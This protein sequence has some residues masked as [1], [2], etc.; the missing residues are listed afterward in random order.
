LGSLDVLVDVYATD[1]GATVVPNIL[2]TSEN[3]VKLEFAQPPANGEF[4][5][6]VIGVVVI[7]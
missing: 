2:R 7:G 3:T 1:G 5:V 6:V 4:R